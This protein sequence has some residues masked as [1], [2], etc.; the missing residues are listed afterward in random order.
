MGVNLRYVD[1]GF[2]DVAG[3]KY[4]A[5]MVQAGRSRTCTI[6]SSGQAKCWGSDELWCGGNKSKTRGL[7]GRGS[8]FCDQRELYHFVC[9]PHLRHVGDEDGEMGN[10]LKP[11][12][13]GNEYVS[14]LVIGSCHT[15][16]LLVEPTCSDGR[17]NGNEIQT[18]CGGSCN[19]C[20][21]TLCSGTCVNNADTP[22]NPNFC[23]VQIA[24]GSRLY[25]VNGSPSKKRYCDSS[26]APGKVNAGKCDKECGYCLACPAPSKTRE[27][28]RVVCWGGNRHGQLAMPSIIDTYGGKYNETVGRLDSILT[29]VRRLSCRGRA[30]HGQCS[31]SDEFEGVNCATPLDPCNH[32]QTCV[33]GACHV[34]S[35][36]VH[37]FNGTMSA[38]FRCTCFVGFEGRR[39]QTDIKAP[40]IGIEN[41]RGDVVAVHIDVLSDASTNYSAFNASKFLLNPNNW[42]YCS[43]DAKKD[44]PDLSPDAEKRFGITNKDCTELPGSFVA[45]VNENSGK[46]NVL[47]ATVNVTMVSAGPWDGTP[48]IHFIKFTATDAAGFTGSGNVLL[49]VRRPDLTDPNV[50]AVSLSV[51]TSQSSNY[52]TFDASNVFARPENW[53]ICSVPAPAVLAS[54]TSAFAVND[55]APSSASR[56]L[57]CNS[58]NGKV[59]PWISDDRGITR[60]IVNTSTLLQPG[61]VYLNV[62]AF[63]AFGNSAS[64]VI[65]LLISVPDIVSPIVEPLAV[66]VLLPPGQE[67]FNVST[68]LS[69]RRRVVCENNRTKSGSFPFKSLGGPCDGKQFQW[70]RDDRGVVSVQANLSFAGLGLSYIAVMA[71]DAYSL[72]TT[73]TI[74]IMVAVID[75][76]PPDVHPFN[77]IVS[78]NTSLPGENLPFNISQ[79]LSNPARHT[80]CNTSRSTNIDL[81]D[82]GLSKVEC[83]A[84]SGSFVAWLSDD[85]AIAKVTTNINLVSNGTTPVLVTATDRFGN[86]GT[87]IVTVIVMKT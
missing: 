47:F 77:L 39:C 71:T 81:N 10:Q 60:V 59:I 48:S 86:V 5:T 80:Y 56:R 22:E 9:D 20:P 58:R 25:L 17:K 49:R 41:D 6:L 57:A 70:I 74:S 67:V 16:A 26:Y 38:D 45:W 4:R 61:I 72:S 64:A 33:F 12:D 27:K 1:L 78:I 42:E 15:C 69:P 3:Q 23:E 65:H 51:Y 46:V 36:F 13:V 2:D 34:Q 8:G 73:T 37:P 68:I 44:T 63:D 82:L 84:L 75:I 19:P 54:T 85:Q 29:G 55:F 62:T 35:A 18:D 53:L 79:I 21:M 50:R 7:L 83:D 87:G 24:L 66:S 76:K 40:V 14:D 52:Q 11:L 31:C 43:K 32:T 28:G 30:S